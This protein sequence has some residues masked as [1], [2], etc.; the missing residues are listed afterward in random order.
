MAAGGPPDP[1]APVAL[2]R[3]TS[4]PSPIS[5]T[6]MRGTTA[7]GS[8]LYAAGSERARVSSFYADVSLFYLPLHLMRVLLTSFFCLAPPPIFKAQAV[9]EAASGVRSAPAPLPSASSY[10]EWQNFD[11][12]VPTD[13]VVDAHPAAAPAPPRPR[14]FSLTKLFRR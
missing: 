3:S 9:A 11:H 5:A 14:R 2:Q 10:L 8:S 4:A 6:G 1:L 7:L 12:V 13:I